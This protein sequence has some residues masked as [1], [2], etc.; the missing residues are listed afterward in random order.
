[1]KKILIYGMLFI[2]LLFTLIGMKEVSIGKPIEIVDP[3]EK[4]DTINT[5][6]LP[7]VVIPYKKRIN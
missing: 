1:M 7:E 6:M 3:I 5:V 4:L 2:G